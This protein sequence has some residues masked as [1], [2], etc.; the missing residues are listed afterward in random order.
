MQIGSYK[1]RQYKSIHI[2]FSKLCHAA[3]LFRDSTLFEFL[4]VIYFVLFNSME[5][6]LLI[7]PLNETF[8]FI[9]Q[10]FI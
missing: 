1:A 8:L 7:M 4:K 5:S 6:S 9:L 2:S 10:N 3:M